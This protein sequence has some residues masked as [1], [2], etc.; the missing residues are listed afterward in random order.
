[1]K[2]WAQLWISI[3]LA[4][5]AYAA[6]IELEISPPE[7]EW[8]LYA[9]LSPDPCAFP[10]GWRLEACPK[11]L[12]PEGI[13][14]IGEQSLIIELGPLLAAGDYEAALR[15]IGL[16]YGPELLLLEAGDIDGFRQTRRP[17][18]GEGTLRPGPG[19]RG[20]DTPTMNFTMDR[21]NVPLAEGRGDTPGRALP[22]SRE[23][24]PDFI[25]ASILYVIGHSYFSL[26][27]YLPA[28]TAFKLVLDALPNH[29]RTHE[30]LA[31]LYLRTERYADARVHLATLAELGRNTAHVQSA[32]GYL[33]QKT[34]RY[35]AAADAFQRALVLAPDDR[36]AQRG[37][38]L[39]LTKTHEHAKA[40]AL[41]EQLLR[42]E[43]D[44]RDLWL[45]RAQI[46]LAANER[47]EALASL[48]TALRLG[49][50]SIENRRACFELHMESGNV[51]R[52]TELL[53]GLRARDLPF[54]LVDQAL[55]WLAN[56]NEWDRYRELVG[57]ID[58][59]AL[60]RVEQSRLLT[61]RASLAARDGSRRAASTALQDALDLDPAN[62]EA[63]MALGQIYRTDRD[64][65]RADL[66]FRRASDYGA[67]RET[68][69]VARAEV[70]SEQQ[71][72]D[73]A[74]AFLR[75]LVATNPARTDLRR[76]VDVLENLQLLRTQR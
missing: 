33:E 43:P 47:G 49:D 6:E 32:R 18:S 60:G 42:A 24:W 34:H 44:D 29:A 71:D 14:N 46:A 27:R 21:S 40:S 22:N 25:S 9:E 50:D 52:A 67:V 62:A 65:G 4:Q 16:N 45:Y 36:G 31:M 64:Y 7:P 39:A 15:R 2:R 13:A 1:M 73:V 58:R 72:Y 28:E 12:M 70:A 17:T 54:P 63:L 55:G 74:L 30:S 38:L 5:V 41:V 57:S 69:L 51:A 26:Q 19:S 37:L 59:A 68:A 3:V 56:E 61:R 76:N 66:L 10:G 35:S 23:R 20:R 48:E 8:L 11:Q 53:R 75:E